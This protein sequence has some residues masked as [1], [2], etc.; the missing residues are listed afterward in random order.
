M[1]LSV[2]GKF[3]ND[4]FD[5][6]YDIVG[7]FKKAVAEADLDKIP[8]CLESFVYFPVIISDVM[9]ISKKSHRSYSRKEQ[10]EFVNVEIPY[11]R[12]VGANRASK[13]SLL[14]DGL[15]TALVGTSVLKISASAKAAILS[16][17]EA[18]ENTFSTAS[19]EDTGDVQQNKGR[20]S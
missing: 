13:L 4:I 10:A 5:D 18:V 8:S 7:V 11:E 12:W 3:S 19:S 17:L 2:S 20:V 6:A 14:L 1:Q 16:R 15:R 9:E